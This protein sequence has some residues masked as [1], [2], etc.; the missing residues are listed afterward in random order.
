MT[1]PD[2]YS[3]P[4]RV[5]DLAARR[6][7]PFELSPSADDLRALAADMGASIVRKL[8]FA[9]TLAPLGK[10]DWRLEAN[11][12]ATVVQPCVVTLAPVTTR[13]DQSVVRTFLADMPKP[14]E[15]EA[16]IPEDDT[17]EPLGP[18]IDLGAVLA[19]ALALAMPLYPR[20]AGAE[21]GEMVAAEP[22]VTPLRD[23]E[24]KPFAGLAALRDRLGDE[25]ETH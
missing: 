4:I 14:T 9:G 23:G 2:P 7:T 1:H 12:G 18:V 25:S 13:I 19:E 6:V 3:H 10:R 8:R 5:A 24:I 17:I 20:A 16:E 22:G 11:L 21:L 15:P